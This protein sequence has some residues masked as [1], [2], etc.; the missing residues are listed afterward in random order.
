MREL[1]LTPGEA[2]TVGDIFVNRL[3]KWIGPLKDHA[4]PLSQ[5]DHIKS[6]QL[7]SAVDFESSPR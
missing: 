1:Y 5:I 4:H 7:I 2:Q 6:G 3:R